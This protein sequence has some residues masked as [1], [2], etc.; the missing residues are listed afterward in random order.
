[1]QIKSNYAFS[2]YYIVKFKDRGNSHML[3]L[4]TDLAKVSLML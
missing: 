3:V 1:M 2:S 4:F